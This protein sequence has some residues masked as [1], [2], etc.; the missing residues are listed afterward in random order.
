MDAMQEESEE[1]GEPV[2]IPAVYG[3]VPAATSVAQMVLSLVE[4]YLV[5]CPTTFPEGTSA[6]LAVLSLARA[7]LHLVS[8]VQ[9][10]RK[11]T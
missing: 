10:V 5:L 11:D 4:V 6:T 2:R 8:S 1:E 3:G 7:A 9:E